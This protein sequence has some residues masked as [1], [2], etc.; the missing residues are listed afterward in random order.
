MANQNCNPHTLDF[1][2]LETDPE[3][4]VV[5]DD[6]RADLEKIGIT[7]NTQ[8]LDQEAYIEAERNGTYNMLFTRT[9]VSASYPPSLK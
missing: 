4:A 6:I 5:E 7:V 8:K 3:M 2:I 1:I 9:W